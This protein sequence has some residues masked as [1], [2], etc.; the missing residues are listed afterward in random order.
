MTMMVVDVH[1]W[2]WNNNMAMAHRMV[3]EVCGFKREVQ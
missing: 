1:N 3:L 2:N